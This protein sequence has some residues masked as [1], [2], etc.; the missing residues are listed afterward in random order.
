MTL[1]EAIEHCE[2]VSRNCE[3]SNCALDHA[4]L[5]YWLKELKM[6][7]EGRAKLNENG[8]IVMTVDSKNIDFL[9]GIGHCTF[10]KAKIY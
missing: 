1:E 4:Q 5:A 2:E 7:K 3:N 9:P 10:S 6:F 8:V